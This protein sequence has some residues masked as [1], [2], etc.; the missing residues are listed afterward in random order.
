MNTT[1][2]VKDAVIRASTVFSED[3][4]AS[5]KKA[6]EVEKNP[7]ARW[8]LEML[9]E[10]AETAEKTRHPTCDDTGIPHIFLE[11][12][13]SQSVSA[14]ML[15][16]IQQGV[17]EGMRALPC[18]PMA[19]KGDDIQRLEQSVGLDDDPGA[20]ALAPI[21]IKTV[22]EDVIRALYKASQAGV[23]IDLIIRGICCLKPNIKGVSENI[24]VI[25]IV[26][27]FL[28]HSRVFIFCNNNNNGYFIG[29]ADLMPRNLDHRI[30]V[31][32]PVIDEDIR[33]E[34]WDMLHIQLKD[35]CKARVSDENGINNYRKTKSRK[36]VRS[37]FETYEYFK[38][39][40]L[41][42]TVD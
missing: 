36:K 6:L 11:V 17:V 12:G 14:E 26:D 18:R 21:R 38:K 24:E 41:K 30:E 35:N 4:K 31:I 25:S 42:L 13:G 28:E 37:Q 15:S 2:K 5:C 7:N 23:K 33:K 22:D 8:M 3:K 19:V 29:S 9:L 40:T 1:T 32:T 39:M 34:I 10:N 20:L 27:R 16:E